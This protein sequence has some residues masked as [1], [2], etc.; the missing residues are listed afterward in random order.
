MQARQGVGVAARAD[1]FLKNL[2]EYFR[3]CC[4][5]LLSSCYSSFP[6]SGILEILKARRLQSYVSREREAGERMRKG[7]NVLALKSEHRLN[8]LN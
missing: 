1:C 8:C 6:S 3:F 7:C 5:M 2:L 4:I